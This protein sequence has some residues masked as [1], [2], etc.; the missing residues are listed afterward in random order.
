[1]IHLHPTE[2]LI[3]KISWFQRAFIATFS[4]MIG[5]VIAR[6]L[7]DP[8]MRKSAGEHQRFS[9]AQL[10]TSSIMRPK[11]LG[12]DV[13]PIPGSHVAIRKYSRSPS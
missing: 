2:S 3:L 4:T 8:A 11:E 13:M 7:P 5:A 10:R 9:L 12:W 6:M 1:M